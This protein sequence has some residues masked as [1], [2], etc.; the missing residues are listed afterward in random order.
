MV[1]VVSPNNTKATLGTMLGDLKSSTDKYAIELLPAD[2]TVVSFDV[3]R[4]MCQ[5]LW[6]SQPERHGTPEER[7]HS[8]VS[9][10]AAEGAVHL[11]ATLMQWFTSGVVRQK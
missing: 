9:Q 2:G 8:N 6:K 7:I 3:V 4:S 11:A 1:P 10:K 5:L